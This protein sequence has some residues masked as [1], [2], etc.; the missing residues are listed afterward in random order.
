MYSVFKMLLLL[1]LKNFSLFLRKMFQQIP[2]L[3]N[4]P[5]SISLPEVELPGSEARRA[6]HTEKQ[7][8]LQRTRLVP[9][10]VGRLKLLG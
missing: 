5:V 2:A 3:K 1:L 7:H 8:L 9:A 10:M 6:R 4:R